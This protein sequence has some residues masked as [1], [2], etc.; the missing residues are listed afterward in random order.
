M[1]RLSQAKPRERIGSP[2]KIK[3]VRKEVDFTRM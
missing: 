2:K 3:P 1:V